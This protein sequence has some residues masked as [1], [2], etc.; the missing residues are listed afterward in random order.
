M[1]CMKK[2]KTCYTNTKKEK[3]EKLYSEG[4]WT[5]EEAVKTKEKEKEADTD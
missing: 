3:W 2:S 5:E 4:G 1:T